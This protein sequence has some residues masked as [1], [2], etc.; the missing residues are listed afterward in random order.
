MTEKALVS[1]LAPWVVDSCG[2]GGLQGP[3]GTRPGRGAALRSWRSPWRPRSSHPGG[4]FLS[5]LS[6]WEQMRVHLPFHPA[7]GPRGAVLGQGPTGGV[8]QARGCHLAVSILS[9]PA[10]VSAAALGVDEPWRESRDA[11]CGA[12]Q[13]CILVMVPLLSCSIPPLFGME[14]RV[15]GRRL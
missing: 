12:E 9:C 5:V 4:C 8:E 7:W 13:A 14:S 6:S 10:H 2:D 11:G 3:Q 1:D 15:P